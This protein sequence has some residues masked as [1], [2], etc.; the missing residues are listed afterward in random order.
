MKKKIITKISEGLGNQL[1][2]YANAY[3]LSKKNDFE[4]YVDPYS[5]YFKKKHAYKY[6]LNRFNTTSKIASPKYIFANHFKHIIKKI[7][8]FFDIF[9]KYKKFIFEKK[10]QN[11]QSKYYPIDLSLTNNIFFLDGNFE[12][13]KYFI[14]FRNDLL[15]E[16]KI[17]DINVFSKNK[18]L[19]LI[20]NNNVV[21]ICVRQNRF[22]ERIKNINDKKSILKSKL[23]V[24]ETMDYIYKS[25]SYFDNKIKNPLYLVWSNDFTGLEKYFDTKKFIFVENND[26][27]V[28]TDFYLLTKCKYFIVGPSTF[29]WWG[30]WLST[31]NDKICLRPKNINPSKNIDFWPEKWKA[32]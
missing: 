26:D 7:L 1:F 8:I 6:F 27:K 23:F 17:K 9:K 14:D 30:A 3:A 19:S 21:S 2:M 16:F 18:Y 29:H 20:E 31:H 24:E 5:G 28:L 10:N 11:K 4:L 32:I 15:A 22:S 12:T 25:I 13:E